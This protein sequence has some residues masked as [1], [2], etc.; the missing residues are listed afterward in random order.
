MKRNPAAAPSTST[1]RSSGRQT[2]V[3]SQ[4]FHYGDGKRNERDVE[5]AERELARDRKRREQRLEEL[6]VGV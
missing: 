5:R 4:G 6:E 3:A 1:A 2:K